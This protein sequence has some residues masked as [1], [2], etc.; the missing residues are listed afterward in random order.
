MTTSLSGGGTDIS[1]L[2]GKLTLG[3]DGYYKYVVNNSNTSVQ[4]LRTASNTLTDSFTYT[5]KDDNGNV[6]T[7]TLTVT[8]Q[9]HDDAPI[10]VNDYSTAKIGGSAIS[11]SVV[12]NDSDVDKNGE[13]IGISG[14]VASGTVSTYSG[15]TAS[16]SFSGLSGASVKLNDTVSAIVGGTAYTLYD[17]NGAAI[18][19][20]ANSSGGTVPI[21]GIASYYVSGSTHVSY[22]FRLGD[23]VQFGS[24]GGAKTGTV[25]TAPTNPSITI[26]MASTTGLPATGMI[27]SSATGIPVGSVITGIA[28]SGSNYVISFDR[29][30]S[31]TPSGA[32]AFTGTISTS[33][34]FGGVYGTLVLYANGN[35]TY[36][37]NA[38]GTAGQDSFSYTVQDA[39]GATSTATLN[40][41]VL[42]ATATNPTAVADTVSITENASPATVSAG[43]YASGLVGND[44]TPTGTTLSTTAAVI[45]GRAAA[46]GSETSISSGSTVTLTGLYGTLALKSDG[47]YVY[48]LNNG[49]AAVNGL[50]TGNSLTDVFYYR[51]QNNGTSGT[52]DLSTLT[53]TINGAN[54][55]PVLKLNA[56][57]GS[58][59]FANSF[60]QGDTSVSL[61]DALRRAPVRRRQHLFL[62]TDRRLHAVCLR[63]RECGT[64]A[65]QRR[66]RQQH[67]HRQPRRT[68]VGQAP[69]ASVSAVSPTPTPRRFSGGKAT[70]SFTPGSAITQGQ[71]D[72]L[73][74]ALRYTNGSGNPTGSSSRAFDI[75]AYDNGNRNDTTFGSNLLASNLATSTITVYN[76][77][78][79]AA[80]TADTVTATE[81]GGTNNT[82]GIDP[83]GNVLI[84]DTSNGSGTGIGDSG[85]TLTVIKASKG[86]TLAASPST[87]TAGGTVITGNYGTLTLSADGSYSYAVDNSNATVQ[88]LNTTST[89]LTDTFTYQISDKV[90]QTASATLTVSIGGADD[91]SVLVADSSAI[92]KNNPASGNVLSNDSDVDNTLSVASFTISGI[93][94]SF[95][96]GSTTQTITGVGTLVLN[97]NGAYTF[98]PVS[99]WTGSVPTITYTTNTGASSTLDIT[100]AAAV[101]AAPMAGNV[102]ASSQ[103]DATSIAVTL[104]GTDGDGSIASYTVTSLPANGSLYSDAALSSAISANTA[105][106]GATVYFVPTADW[107]GSTSFAYKVTDNLGTMSAATATASISLSAVTDIAN[108]SASTGEDTAVTTNVLTNDSFENNG[109]TITAVGA[110]SH[111]T[112]AIADASLGTVTYTPDANWHGSDSYT[113]TVTSGGVTETATVSVTVSQ[114]NDPVTFGGD[115]SKSGNEDATLTGTLSVSDNADGISTP[116]FRIANGNGPAHGNAS[117]DA[118]TG[119]WS[120]TPTAD[121]NGSDSFTVSVTDNDGNVETRT[122]SLSVAAVADIANDSASTAEDTAVTT[123]VLTND[124]FENNGRMITAV[125]AASHGTVAIADASLG[126]VTY[127]PDANWHGSDSYTYTVTSGGVTETATVSVTVSQVND[128]V[129]F[130]GD[131]SKSGNEDAT[132]TGT[133]SV[134]D[135]ADGISTPNFRIANGNGP[136]HGNASIDATTGV[137]SYTPTAD[138]NGSDSFT[139][140]VTDN[141]GNVE[142]RTISLTVAAVAD[143]AND[144]ASTGEDAAVTTNVLTNDSFENNGRTIAAVGAASHGTVTIADASLGT[145]T[146]TPDAN[147]HGSDS[148][149]YT[150]TSGDV[151]ET[152]TVNVT[153]SAGSHLA[154]IDASTNGNSALGA[155]TE[156]T[157]IQAGN[158][159]KSTGTL[160]V[161]D[162]DAGEDKFSTTVTPMS[163]AWGT[164][165]ITE[166]GVWTYSVDNG[167]AALQAMKDGDTRTETFSV[168]SADG[169]ATQTVTITING[170]NDPATINAGTSNA[171]AIGSVTED[172]SIQAGN[173]LKST[174]TLAVSDTDTGEA[175]FSTTVTPMS[176][177]WG[178]LTITDAGVWTYSVDNG[179][180]ALQAMKAGDTRTE[181]FTVASA[182]GSATQTVTITINSTNDELAIDNVTVNEASPYS[183]FRITGTSGQQL[184]LELVPTG[185]NYAPLAGNAEIGVDTGTQLQYFDGRG[186]INYSTG[187]SITYPSGSTTLLVRVAIVND[188][189]YE[190]PES[191]KLKA[192]TDTLVAYGIS[193]IGD[194]GRGAIFNESGAE[195]LDPNLVRDDDRSLKVDS[196]NVNEASPYAVFTV[197][198]VAGNGVTLALAATTADSGNATLGTDT[199]TQLQT[200]DNG[201]WTNYTTGA[202]VIVP[203]SGLLQVR[204]AIIND[205]VGEGAETFRLNVTDPLIGTS[206]G[207]ATIHD[208]GTGNY[209]LDD[210]TTP[211]TATQ[212]VVAGK[213]LDDDFDRDGI[214]PNVE[215]I[216]ATMSASTGH[217]GAVG[218]LNN[219]GIPDAE[220]SAV[221]T[222]AWTTVDKFDAAVSGTLT[223]VKPIITVQAVATNNVADDTCFQLQD[224]KVLPTTGSASDGNITGGRP[225]GGN[226]E[227]ITTPWDPIQFTVA[228]SASSSG[229]QDLDPSR[230]GTQIRIVIDI[231][232]AGMTTGDF[233]AYMKY[234]SADTITAAIA[235]T[236]LDGKAIT[237][238]GWYDFT[239]RKDANGN[240][241]GDGARFVLATDGKTIASI[242]LTLTD[243]AFGDDS[244]AVGK[245]LDPGVPVWRTTPPA[246]ATI[247]AGIVV[248][249]DTPPTPRNDA[250]R[251]PEVQPFTESPHNGVRPFDSALPTFDTPMHAKDARLIDALFGTSSS[252]TFGDSE[253]IALRSSPTWERWRRFGSRIRRFTTS[254]T[255]SAFPAVCRSDAS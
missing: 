87:I 111:G 152:A 128:P 21:S 109:R 162:T 106:G 182:D 64:T 236:D 227:T 98:T 59:N 219:D 110:A 196:F 27:V 72:T 94:G 99:N 161:S 80:A 231:S 217:G 114:V 181:T 138:W 77:N 81:A 83:S 238:A 169:S 206:F 97:T 18:Y 203:A 213:T 195:N 23:S 41:N 240:Y 208:D 144:S 35:Y 86:S 104:S 22:T 46:D 42:A 139:V 242:Q 191:F 197:T 160:A 150:V 71:L 43:T 25:A 24:G 190:G 248:R 107:N 130:G 149:T 159:L 198:G 247:P 241:V 47:T 237:Q 30:F 51:I 234:V 147:W 140:S 137:W 142:T 189:V 117:I 1:G 84:G 155:V 11:G 133:L 151:T 105:F 48:T 202:T 9:G 78:T 39:A 67:R 200:L 232:R 65:D 91:A 226:G 93:V 207:T 37:P 148:Y 70:L 143:I 5:V 254:S 113:Y 108:D 36:T 19:C 214:A 40:I 100:V 201:H 49:N 132:L 33:A 16:I 32:I 165:T 66:D 61:G 31:G 69:A 54:D 14:M 44:T 156:D 188:A 246:S 229:L 28:T 212:L 174:G 102:S 146:Y 183:V 96:A 136:A 252:L 134:S 176:G 178:T 63:R 34:S 145:V 53:V 89:K 45:A 26:S 129:T 223:E 116:N 194:D 135:N 224:I 157:S 127:T 171:N 38:T 121:W 255:S 177:A 193:T 216:L 88:A 123:N 119:V 245:V 230:P 215:E 228:P 74:T 173:T 218:D 50:N 73:L 205:A 222:I 112:V 4:A 172:T 103:E 56:A 95:T 7:T 85:D 125:G 90:N 209:W 180:A 249:P 79:A 6:A 186:W 75:T 55:A 239:Q 15:G 158:M 175:K 185:S 17:A 167:K 82:G 57:S 153:V 124:S 58:T 204:V 10:A 122:I 233:N 235:L 68:D 101:N 92:I 199:G 192:S 60:T 12:T 13:T 179:K 141:D 211:A 120:Y 253:R 166:A 170:T 62:E 164:L 220:Q 29:A 243:N 3:A 187:S 184:R 250:F 221:T 251:A 115:T 163:G 131:T 244:M 118:T 8:I 20:T 126:T 154:T 168:A 225:V 52:Q 210:N 2:Y 76:T